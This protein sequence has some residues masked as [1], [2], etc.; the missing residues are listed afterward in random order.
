M[1]SRL[2]QDSICL[3]RR[4][5]IHCSSL[6]VKNFFEVRSSRFSNTSGSLDQ[7]FKL[8][9]WRSNVTSKTRTRVTNRQHERVRAPNIRVSSVRNQLRVTRL[10]PR[11]LRLGL[12]EVKVKFYPNPRHEG[13]WGSVVIPR[14][15]TPAPI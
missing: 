15:R 14:E 11:V 3:C 8:Y 1:P 6:Q 5:I 9:L 12:G 7:F 13:A 4:C 10:V 2:C